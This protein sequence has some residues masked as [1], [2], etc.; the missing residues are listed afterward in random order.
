MTGLGVTVPWSFPAGGVVGW[1][2]GGV[3]GAGVTFCGVLLS[4]GA[5]VAG[6]DGLAVVSG[7]Y[8]DS[9]VFSD[10]KSVV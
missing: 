4:T 10:R 1:F 6:M 9:V 7:L 3:A 5:G 8:S 2:A